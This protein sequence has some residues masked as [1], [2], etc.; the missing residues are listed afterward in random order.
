MKKTIQPSATATQVDRSAI[1]FALCALALL[2][3]SIG[4]MASGMWPIVLDRLVGDGVIILIWLFAAVGFGAAILSICKIACKSIALM[5]ASAAGIG[6]GVMSLVTL[7]LGLFGAL[8]RQAAA[9]LLAI[10]LTLGIVTWFVNRASWHFH[11]PKFIAMS[12]SWLIVIAFGAI[13]IV[14][15]LVPAGILWGDEPNGYDVVEYHLQVLREWFEAG[16]ISALPHNVYSFFPMNVEMHYL[17][18]MHL[19]SGPWAG[20]YV[21]QMMHLIFVGLSV[22]AVYGV[23]RCTAKPQ[24]AI[25]S[26]VAMAATPWIV[27]LASVAYDEGGLL[28][29]GA[30]SIGWTM[31]AMRSPQKLKLMALAGI[32]AGLACGVKLTAAPM[33]LVA[34]PIAMMRRDMMKSIGVFLIAGIIAFS[35]WLIRNFVWTGN[36]IFPE[37]MSIFGRGHFSEVQVQRWNIAHAPREDQR[38]IFGRMRAFGAQVV[39]D[40]RYGFYLSPIGLVAGALSRKRQ[41][42]RFLVFLLILQFIVWIGF[43]HLQGR[44]FVLA[45]PIAAM[46][47][48]QVDDLRLQLVTIGGAITSAIIGIVMLAPRISNVAGAIGSE[49][50]QS[51]LPQVV[52]DALDSGRPI[53]LAG[54]AK[55][56]WY[57]I[58]MSRLT[59]RTV[60]DVDVQPGESLIDAW[61]RGVPEHAIVVVDPNELSR[62]SRTYYGLAKFGGG[63]TYVMEKR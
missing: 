1:Y 41:E 58:P 7:A 37:A 2:V 23:V 13:A 62:L 36:P 48:G 31:I 52:T 20:M 25:V 44:F 46:L 15:A 34:I 60:F 59:Y 35:P 8:S 29:F 16:R 27:M 55:A 26:A 10:G 12:W 3:G 63:E 14:G 50:V 22:I 40:W 5:F 30:L 51:I 56:F 11:K 6:F 45:I 57:Q 17:L 49:N 61:T 21:A 47:I 24:A 53:A 19:R 4:A 38:G 42:M 33:L 54:D 28:L 32:F 39:I 9:A 18:A 43:T